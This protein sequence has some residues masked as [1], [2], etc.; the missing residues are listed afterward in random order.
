[1]KSTSG[2]RILVL[3]IL[4]S[5]SPHGGF[6]RTE[7]TE[8]EEIHKNLHF[9]NPRSM[10]NRIVVD[11][12][13]GSINV[14]GYDGPSVELIVHKTIRAESE[15][16][17]SEARQKI[18]VETTEDSERIL[19]YVKTPWRCENGHSHGWNNY[20]YDADCDFE[21]KVP[22]KTDF[23]LKTVNN[24]DISVKTIE[25]S[26]EVENVNGS[27]AMNNIRGAGKVS[28]VNGDVTVRLAS[29]PA[30]ACSFSTVNGKVDVAFQ[31]DLSANIR[32]KTLNG[33]VYTDFVV[34]DLPSPP[35]VRENHH[36]RIVYRSGDSFSVKVGSGGP[37]LSFNTLNGNI[38]IVKN[39]D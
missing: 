6:A 25:G 16:A 22:A 15:H 39:A 23:F 34:K 18:T 10:S 36:R 21:I 3:A 11:N 32:L 1:M 17:L 2:S 31:N 12:I 24:G 13:N 37:E 8:K 33:N 5:C 14:V 7:L 19:I 27:I 20:G 4:L 9:A 38:Y 30:T 35:A 29:N 26:F 28:T